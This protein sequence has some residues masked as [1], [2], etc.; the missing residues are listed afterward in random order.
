MVGTL[1]VFELASALLGRKLE[2]ENLL[3]GTDP[4]GLE[5]QNQENLPNLDGIEG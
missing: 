4:G 1:S 3:E 2:G 5:G